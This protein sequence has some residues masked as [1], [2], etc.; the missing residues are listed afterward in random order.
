MGAQG[1]IVLPAGVREA[2][3]LRPGDR[4]I[5]VADEDGILL[6]TPVQAVRRAQAIARRCIP[7]G[8]D[9]VR[10]LLEE[11]RREALDE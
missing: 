8:R 5:V 1:R 7:A 3:H 11:R 9:L 2:A 6:L 10:E 4:L